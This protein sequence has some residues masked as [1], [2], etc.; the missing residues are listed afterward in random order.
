MILIARQLS[1][2]LEDARVR[3]GSGDVET[4]G[5]HFIPFKRLELSIAATVPR[6]GLCERQYPFTVF[7]NKL[8]DESL[9]FDIYD[10]AR[11][12][13]ESHI[14]SILKIPKDSVHVVFCSSSSDP[15]YM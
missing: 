5:S 12:A 9:R 2:P 4:T 14:S 13:V 11:S 3:L 7:T 8:D 10:A 6:L 1:N 15:L